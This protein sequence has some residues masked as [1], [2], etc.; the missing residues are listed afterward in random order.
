MGKAFLD[1]LIIL[2]A[3]VIY[4]AGLGLNIMDVDSAQYAS[5]SQEM[6]RTN[7]FLE[8]QNKGNDYLDKP[9]LLFWVSAISF[10][11]FGVHNWSFKLIPFLFAMMSVFAT[12]RLG[13]IM[14]NNKVG[15][16]AAVILLT[17]Q[18]YFL[19]TMDLRT[20]TMLT[21]CVALA[22]WQIMEFILGDKKKRRLVFGF[23]FVGLAMLAKGPL[24]L[25]VPAIAIGSHLLMNRQWNQILRWE[26]LVGLLITAAV[27]LPMS[28][29][30]YTQ[31]DAR[32]DNVVMMPSP[33]GMTPREGVS[34]LRFYFWE[35]SFGRITGEN[36]WKDSS[37][38][39]F[40]VHNF[41]WSFAP[42]SLFALVAFFWKIRHESLSLMKNGKGEFLTLLGF[43]IPFIVL[44]RSH[45]KLPHYIFPLYPFAAIFTAQ[46]IY[47]W[48]VEAKTKAPKLATYS[49]AIL[50]LLSVGLL[51]FTILFYV[52]PIPT[53]VRWIF[54][55]LVGFAIW[56]LT[57]KPIEYVWVRSI[58]VIAL[59]FN[60]V[61]NM[62]FYP[63]LLKYQKGSELA[64]IAFKEGATGQ[65]TAYLK[66]F[67][68]SFDVYMKADIPVRSSADRI[69]PNETFIFTTKEGLEELKKSN[70]KISKEIEFLGYPV[71]NL[72]PKFLN[73]QTRE[74]ALSKSFLV[75]LADE[76]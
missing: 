29:G 36:V 2:F 63:L 1:W 53:A 68:Y 70:H 17:C 41:L 14:V 19:F 44:S 4:M 42:W 31:F 28:Y 65:N 34:G 9:P 54:V 26:W 47:H 35:Q 5:I 6:A 48:I 33:S 61:M 52:F 62:H 12:Y 72:R 21:A 18:A 71:T 46:C 56:L 43:L 69:K 25:V 50:S 55:L 27:L 66:D 38:P 16:W 15:R 32:P 11:I 37:G 57:Q 76:R 40:F 64:S 13:T 60:M 75:V 10:K 51:G 7:E 39:F 8:V 59:G 3:M 49:I 45:F 58:I 20:D 24:G 67:T 73:P 23:I 74:S 30:L 22:V